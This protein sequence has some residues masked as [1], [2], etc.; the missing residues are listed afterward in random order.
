VIRLVVAAVLAC[1]AGCALAFDLQGHRGARGHR[2]ENTLPAFEHALRTGVTTLELDL[3]LTAD[4][5]VV[6]SHDPVLHADLARGPDGQWLGSPVVIHRT[7][8]QQLQ[9][10]D[11]GRLRP[12]SD[13]ARAFAQQQPVDGTRIP[14]LAA[15]FELAQR[16]GASHVQ[17]NVETK[18]DLRTPQNTPA[19]EAFVRAV[20]EVVRRAGVEG[21]VTVQSFD[22][23]TLQQV[24]R[25]APRLRTAYLTVQ[26]ERGSNL[27]DAQATAG[28]RLAEHGSV[29][30][31]VKAAGGR[32]WSPNFAA[33][34]GPLVRE[35]QSLG[36][37]VIPWTVNEP[38]DIA[39]VLDLGVDGI[40]SDYPDRVRAELQ[41]RGLPLPPRVD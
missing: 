1:V 4:G 8:W 37:Q 21:R 38:A 31:L 28:F 7:S 15:V 11:V 17:F 29:P 23:R 34:T 32:V 12:G 24:Q 18:M 25:L 9:Q 5:V 3:A 22:W 14:T 13:Y 19:P 30:R 41:R 39:R 20:L 40:I 2:P 10:Y 35:A 33:L 36:L 6:V 27:D 26:S 16:L